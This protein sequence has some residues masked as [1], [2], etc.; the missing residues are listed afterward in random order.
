MKE[1]LE[2]FGLVEVFAYLCPGAILLWSTLLWAK[3][4]DL[5]LPGGEKET[6]VT[7]ALSA[8]LLILAYTLGLVVATLS[9]ELAAFYIR[10]AR[11]QRTH[12]KRRVPS[13]FVQ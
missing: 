10:H 13:G 11:A 4:A 1:V 3:P 7:F 5:G 9:S 2:K 12:W 6:W 8:F